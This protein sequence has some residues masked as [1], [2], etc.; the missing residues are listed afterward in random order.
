[1][2]KIS[3]YYQSAGGA[4]AIACKDVFFLHNKLDSKKNWTYKY[5]CRS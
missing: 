5:V 4:A 3:D 2:K 1:M